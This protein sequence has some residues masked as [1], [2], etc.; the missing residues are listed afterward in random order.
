MSQE[1][2]F[3]KN[4]EAY[5]DSSVHSDVQDLSK[6]LD[7]VKPIEGRECL[8]IATGTGHTAFYLAKQLGHVFAVDIN[9]EMLAVAQEEADKKSLSVRFLKSESTELFFDDD[10]FDL[11]ACRL[12]AHH[13]QDVCGFLA[14]VHRVSRP[15]GEFILIDN[16]VPECKETAAW[17]NAYEQ[18]RDPSHQACLTEAN[19]VALCQENGFEVVKTLLHEEILEFQPWME[20]MSVSTAKQDEMWH[21]LQS[22]PQQIRDY[23]KVR[24]E[25]EIRLITLTRLILVATRSDLGT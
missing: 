8:D 18:E 21:R 11:V 6:A 22:A 24:I 19:W 4:A 13:F 10:A 3:S 5:R 9:A 17:L 15:R 2:G 25:D 14:E 20:R 12:A 23:W 7:F 1:N 16:V